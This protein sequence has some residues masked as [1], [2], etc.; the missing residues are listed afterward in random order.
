MKNNENEKKHRRR[1]RSLLLSLVF[2]AIILS[3]STFAWFI[4]MRTVNVSSF[5]VTIASTKDL[6]LSLNGTKWEETVTINATNFDDDVTTGSGTVYD[7]HTNWWAGSGLIPMSSV[8]DIDIPSSRLK[9][10]EKSSMTAT[11]GGYRLMA[12]QV[13]NTDVTKGEVNGY[14]AFDLFI[15]NFSGTNYISSLN[16]ADEEAI[17]LSIDSEVSVAS[18]G[19]QNT[20]IENSVRIAFAQIGRVIGT[21]AD[22]SESGDAAALALI[23]GIDCAGTAGGVTGICRTA[24]IWEPNDTKHVA[25]AINWYETSCLKRIA[26]ELT[27]SASY[28]GTCGTVVNGTAYPTYAVNSEIGSSDK[29]DVYD[30]NAYNSYTG[31]IAPS[32]DVAKL[33]AFPYFTDS[34]KIKTGIQRPEFITLAPNSV[35]KVRV[36]IWIEGQDIDNY[37]FA[38]IGKAITVGFGFTKQRF[39][40]DDIN[41]TGPAIR[42][43]LTLTGGDTVSLALD[44][45]W[46]ELG[47]TVTDN[48]DSINLT[49]A[50]DT[51]IP[52]YVT[53]TGTVDHTTA[54]TY[55]ITYRATNGLGLTTTKVRTV[56]VS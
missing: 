43:V 10:F 34:H 26:K 3:V 48:Y 46:T 51:S 22:L 24:Q 23:T 12:S 11:A 5:D 47:Y 42:P 19:V 41:Y 45:P 27:D 44:T 13:P 2:T 18:S 39:T 37:D 17:Y 15:R 33:T 40:E 4:G 21:T 54:G 28:D 1:V 35:T 53:I 50:T 52:K 30:G 31:S 36:Y 32:G 49:N 56:T 9:L 7:G 55:L 16:P 38:A 8:G 14:V 25:G 6:L 20:G 29:V